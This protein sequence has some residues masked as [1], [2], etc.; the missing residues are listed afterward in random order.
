MISCHQEQLPTP[1]PPAQARQTY[2]ICRRL[3]RLSEP[4][5]AFVLHHWN[6][7]LHCRISV[8][9][10]KLC[11][12]APPLN[13]TNLR[14]ATLRPFTPRFSGLS[15]RLR[16][17]RHMP[18]RYLRTNV[19]SLDKQH[20]SSLEM[21]CTVNCVV[22]CGWCAPWAV[23]TGLKWSVDVGTSI[24]GTFLTAYACLHASALSAWIQAEEWFTIAC[25]SPPSSFDEKNAWTS[26]NPTGKTAHF[27]FKISLLHWSSERDRHC[28]TTPSNSSCRCNFTDRL[29]LSSALRHLPC[30]FLL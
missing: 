10:M 4:H 9:P 1:T 11:Q 14:Q 5:E 7:S 26:Q 18:F 25:Q 24:N 8:I 22:F 27:R 28:T 13:R 20:R 12:S 19:C 16:L 6:V 15:A 29:R 30:C 21:L 23:Q 3:I 2:P 17:T